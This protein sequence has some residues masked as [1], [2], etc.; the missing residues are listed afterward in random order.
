MKQFRQIY[1]IDKT[2][3]TKKEM[4]IE[5]GYDQHDAE[6]IAKKLKKDQIREAWFDAYHKGSNFYALEKIRKSLKPY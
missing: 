2:N 6:N 1:S 4:L 3:L 5:I